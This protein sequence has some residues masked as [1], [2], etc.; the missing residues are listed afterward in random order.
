MKETR[1][2]KEKEEEA[3]MQEVEDTQGLGKVSQGWSLEEEMCKN[4]IVKKPTVL[5][6]ISHL[7]INLIYE[8]L[9][10]P[11]IICKRNWHI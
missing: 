9:V 11:S 10:S 7:M 2:S 8:Q 1:V 4:V 6:T 5:I 3:R